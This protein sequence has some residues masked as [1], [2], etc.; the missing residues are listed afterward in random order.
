MTLLL[1]HFLVELRVQEL[2]GGDV[3]GFLDWKVARLGG[4]VGGGVVVATEAG[5]VHGGVG[6][7]HF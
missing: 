2:D 4:V 1:F 5:V 6:V 7:A 3:V